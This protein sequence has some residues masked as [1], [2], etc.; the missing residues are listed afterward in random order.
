MKT[1][2]LI[3]CVSDLPSVYIAAAG[4]LTHQP[5]KAQ[6]FNTREEAEKMLRGM[7]FADTWKAVAHNLPDAS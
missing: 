1:V 2:W 7:H 5:L 3:E 6:R 4:G